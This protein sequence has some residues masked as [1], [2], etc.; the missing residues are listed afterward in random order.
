MKLRLP[1]GVEIPLT[2][3]VLA[4]LAGIGLGFAATTLLDPSRWP[5]LAALLTLLIA[6]CVYELW[7][8][9]RARRD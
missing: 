7:H 6:G 1:G 5:W 4:A 2:W 3:L 8:R 9:L